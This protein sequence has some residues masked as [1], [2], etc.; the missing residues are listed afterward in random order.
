MDAPLQAETKALRRAWERHEAAFLRD[1][2]VAGVEDPR[3]NAQSVLTRHF[4][5]GCVFGDRFAALRE[6]ELR[7]AAA[8]NWLLSRRDEL[9]DPDARAGLRFGLERDAENVE[10]LVIPRFV[11]LLWRSLPMRADEVEV[12]HYLDALLRDETALPDL[13]N[14]PCAATFAGLWRDRLERETSARQPLP[15]LEVACGSANDYRALVAYGL[16]RWLDYTGLD[17]S[18]K[19][20]ANARARFPEAR[21]AVGNVLALDAGDRAFDCVIAHDLFEHLSPEALPVAVAECCRV[22][23]HAACLGCFSAAERA[24]HIIRPTGDYHWNTLS[25][26]RLVELFARHGFATRV[27][28]VGTLLAWLAGD[29]TT[30]NPDAYTL[31]LE[32]R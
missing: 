19:N 21:F 16:A 20:I 11:R 17:L 1:Y 14:T 2:L 30:H 15:V 31:M 32:R 25:V 28:H 24:E 8:L 22:A 18:P 23:R 6:A 5:L 9:A 13:L 27:I 7:F 12:P 4:L 3:L 29:A 26:A 10:G